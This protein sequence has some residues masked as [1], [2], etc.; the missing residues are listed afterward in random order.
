MQIW[1]FLSLKNINTDYWCSGSSMTLMLKKIKK[2]GLQ[3]GKTLMGLLCQ[4]AT[5]T[6]LTLWNS[7]AVQRWHCWQ[8]GT[9]S[10]CNVDIVD[11]VEQFRESVSNELRFVRSKANNICF[12]ITLRLLFCP[13]PAMFSIVNCWLL[14]ASGLS[15]R[16][17]TF[18]LSKAD[19]VKHEVF[20]ALVHSSRYQTFGAMQN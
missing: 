1:S 14:Q 13:R 20:L 10:K 17:K 6:L 2:S 3:H 12:N 11:T 18:I 8:C 7:F 19:N 4:S 16:I 5:L 9:V 15:G